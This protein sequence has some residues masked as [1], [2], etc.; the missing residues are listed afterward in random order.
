M[1]ATANEP[2][3]FLE[4]ARAGA[5]ASSLDH[6]LSVVER[7]EILRALKRA[8]GRRTVAA[9]L[10]GISRSRLYRRMDALGIIH[11]DPANGRA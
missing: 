11:A 4:R 9:Q 1:S 3:V 7:K 5:S 6:L 8:G 2:R 10:L